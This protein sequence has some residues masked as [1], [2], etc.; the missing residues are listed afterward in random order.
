[1]E[2]SSFFN[3]VDGDRQYD[4]EQFAAF[5]KLFLSTGLYHKDNVPA[6]KVTKATGL[7][8]QAEPGSAFLEGYMYNNTED[9]LLTHSAADATNPRID[10]VVLRLDRGVNSRYIKAFVKAGTPATSPVP[11]TLQRDDIIYEVSLAQVR[12]NAGA[13]TI[14]SVTDERL[15]QSVAGLVTSLIT[16]PTDEFE[17]EW[18][19]WFDGIKEQNPAY[20]GMTIYVDGTAPSAPKD[21]DI[22][23]DTSG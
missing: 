8:S 9:I 18:R 7:Q 6:L 2:E 15:D 17:A 16:V 11:P 10:R 14:A 22:W 4:M 5:F 19:A 20:G 3:S 12:V 21:K 1:M 23:I 13:T